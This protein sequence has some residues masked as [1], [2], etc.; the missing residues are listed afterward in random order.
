MP[1]MAPLADVVNI[2]RQTAVVAY[3]LGDGCSNAIIPTG[4]MMMAT[5]SFG[6]IPYI[7]WVKFIV[8]WLLAML[9]TGFIFCVIASAIH[10][11][12]F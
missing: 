12:P 7:R 3:Q 1:L 2:T 11:D 5:I 6:K 4:A 8:K 10:L 9:I